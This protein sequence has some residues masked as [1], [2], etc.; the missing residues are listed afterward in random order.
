MATRPSGRKVSG[1]SRGPS[2]SSVVFHEPDQEDEEEQEEDEEGQETEQE[3]ATALAPGSELSNEPEAEVTAKSEPETTPP[4]PPLP[5]VARTRKA[6]EQTRLGVGRPAI[7]GGTGAR[8][9][10]KSISLPKRGRVSRTVVN[11]SQDTIMEE[12]TCTRS[13][14]PGFVSISGIQAEPSP[15]GTVDPCE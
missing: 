15:S 12:G 14:C 9:V 7:A 4:P 5:P 13:V 6:K 8:A 10:T 1:R 11:P 2:K 3:E